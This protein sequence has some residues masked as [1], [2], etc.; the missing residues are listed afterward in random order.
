MGRYERDKPELGTK[1]IPHDR[2]S[3][4]SLNQ[5][6]KIKRVTACSR[7]KKFNMAKGLRGNLLRNRSGKEESYHSGT[8]KT[9]LDSILKA[10]GK[11]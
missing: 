6:L 2:T 10:T 11:C 7:N 1:G 8:C 5:K 4:H 3:C 9:R